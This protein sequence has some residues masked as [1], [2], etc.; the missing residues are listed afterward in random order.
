MLKSEN[1]TTT[2]RE[3]RI[4]DSRKNFFRFRTSTTT[5]SL[6]FLDRMLSKKLESIT[7]HVWE[8]P[9]KVQKKASE[10]ERINLRRKG[11]ERERWGGSKNDS[12]WVSP[13]SNKGDLNS[14]SHHEFSCQI[15]EIIKSNYWNLSHFFSTY[16]FLFLFEWMRIYT[17]RWLVKM[18]NIIKLEYWIR[19]GRWRD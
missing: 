2:Y 19:G 18:T 8:Q 5:L 14:L 17:R 6:F 3:T 1:T 9:S 15:F 13:M 11:R 16:L 12:L 7:L 4:W 10:G